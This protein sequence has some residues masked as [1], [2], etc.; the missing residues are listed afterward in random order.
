MHRQS[1]ADL[2]QAAK[3]WF[4]RPGDQERPEPVDVP[5]VAAPVP[6]PIVEHPP[7]KEEIV[8]ITPVT[9]DLPAFVT[10]PPPPVRHLAEPPPAPA[11]APVE[12]TA[13]PDTDANPTGGDRHP[14]SPKPFFDPPLIA[15]RAALGLP[16]G[17]L[18]ADFARSQGVPYAT[19]AAAV[20]RE[21]PRDAG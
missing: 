5:E 4:T 1:R 7:R 6:P 15:Q 16:T 12:H 20:D 13:K 21:M 9:G 19:V 11:S 14:R 18:I 10:P 17:F 8:R 2:E 3:A